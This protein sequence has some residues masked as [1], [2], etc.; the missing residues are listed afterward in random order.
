MGPS[1]PCSWA[2]PLQWLLGRLAGWA[3][4][5]RTMVWV[6]QPETPGVRLELGAPAHGG[7][8]RV[9]WA[10][11]SVLGKEIPN[12]T[13]I[14]FPYLQSGDT[15]RASGDTV[16]PAALCS[17]RRRWQAGWVTAVG[18]PDRGVWSHLAKPHL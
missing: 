17:P 15:V 1:G 4:P 8:P 7:S 14:Q 2:A 18:T 9:P 11:V 5:S 12:L 16:D 13:V 3:G 6:M 10:Q